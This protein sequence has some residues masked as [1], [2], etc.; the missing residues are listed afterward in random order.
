M[1]VS[2]VALLV[3]DSSIDRDQKGTQTVVTTHDWYLLRSC[4]RARE[5]RRN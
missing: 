2:F 5:K 4:M 3:T 1:T